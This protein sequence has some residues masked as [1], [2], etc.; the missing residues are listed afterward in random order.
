MIRLVIA[1]EPPNFKDKVRI[2]GENARAILA[3]RPLPHKRT[4][5]P[6]KGTKKAGEQEAP[7]TLR[8]FDYWTDCMDELYEAYH[9]ICAYYCFYIDRAAGPHCEHFVALGQDGED[10]VY[11]WT[12]YR[13]ACAH[14]NSCKREFSDILDPA[15]IQDGWFQL[16]LVTLDVH[17]DPDL[18]SHQKERVQATIKRLKLRFGPALE[19]RRRAMERFRNGLELSFLQTDHPFLARELARQ[20]IVNRE[21]LPPLPRIVTQGEEPEL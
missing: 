12:N 4:G 20:G 2:P 7:K 18:P 6:I 13:L 11:E 17:A 1:P 15:T 16:D 19:T 14:A 9:G 10:L 5:R 21:Q 3:G 8:D